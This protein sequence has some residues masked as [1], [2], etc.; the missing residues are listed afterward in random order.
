MK[1]A[2]RA[3][4]SE[5]FKDVLREI[6]KSRLNAF[7]RDMDGY[8]PQGKQMYFNDHKMHIVKLINLLNDKKTFDFELTRLRSLPYVQYEIRKNKKG[9]R[10]L[11]AKSLPITMRLYIDGYQSKMANYNMGPYWMCSDIMLFHEARG[12]EYNRLHIYADK[13][14]THGNRTPHHYG[15]KPGGM[16]EYGPLDMNESTCLGSFSS[17][18]YSLI[19]AGDVVE[20]LRSLYTYTERHNT[21][22]PLAAQ[23]ASGYPWAEV[24]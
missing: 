23:T 22:S 18:L 19:R 16:D 15:S 7:Q 13:N 21:S 1:I 2:P 10:F 5:E 20:Y 14:P 3:S 8:S 24:I 12:V 9:A 17:I 11:C 6:Y 4:I